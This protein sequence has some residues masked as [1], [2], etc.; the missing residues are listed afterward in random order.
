LRFALS[1]HYLLLTLPVG[2][3]ALS[4]SAP[5]V[6]LLPFLILSLLFFDPAALL[7]RLPL[8]LVAPSVLT[9][10]LLLPL[11]LLFQALPFLNL[12]LL[13]FISALL[14]AAPPPVLALLPLL[15]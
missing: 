1:L 12:S 5:A 13:L 3:V 7:V 11:T 8:P 4:R 6:G 10:C 2:V 9:L 15:I 14:V